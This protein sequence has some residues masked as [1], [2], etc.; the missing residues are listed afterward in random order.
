LGY[1]HAFS[2]KSGMCGRAKLETDVSEIKIAF[3]VPPEYPTPNFPP[4]WNVAPTDN[5]PIVRHDP[6][7]GPAPSI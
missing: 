5:L 4:L 6:K 2:I 1:V 3:R 7:A